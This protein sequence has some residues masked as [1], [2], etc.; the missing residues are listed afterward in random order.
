MNIF[1]KN[2]IRK[3]K[4]RIRERGKRMW[5]RANYMFPRSIRIN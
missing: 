1:L 5:L 2:L 3:T 4:Q